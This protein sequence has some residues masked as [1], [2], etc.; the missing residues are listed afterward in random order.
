[1]SPGGLRM[2]REG[3]WSGDYTQRFHKPTDVQHCGYSELLNTSVNRIV[4]ELSGEAPAVE[5]I[6][7]E[8]QQK[9]HGKGA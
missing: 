8:Q 1:M 6:F 4:K 5:S 2:G 9:K 3:T 7:A